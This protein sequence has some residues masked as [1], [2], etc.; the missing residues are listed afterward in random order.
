MAFL[1]RIVIDLR[2]PNSGFHNGLQ[3]TSMGPA[4]KPYLVVD[5]LYQVGKQ[6]QKPPQALNGPT[7]VHRPTCAYCT[8]ANYLTPLPNFRLSPDTDYHSYCECNI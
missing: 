4:D 8:A 5:N 6:L 3:F 2:A 1:K 7:S